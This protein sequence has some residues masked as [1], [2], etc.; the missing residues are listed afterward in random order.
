MFEA[1][2][3]IDILNGKCVRLKQGA[4]NA[5]TIYANDP[6]EIAHKWQ[7]AGAR[8]IHIVDLDGARTGMPKNIE[9]I[10][11]I[12]SQIKLPIQIGGGIRSFE[13]ITELIKFGVDRVIL[14][15]TAVKNPNLLSSICQEFP[16]NIVVSI[17][18]KDDKVT[19][20]GWTHTSRK[21]IFTLANEAINF[22]V[23]RFVYTDISRDGMLSGPN[24]EGI[25]R[26]IAKVTVPVIAS[27]G[28][29]S[30]LDI[31]NVSQ[32]GAEAVIVGKALYEGRIKP[33]ELF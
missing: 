16:D 12:V 24:I 20:D 18:A 10:K 22:G 31:E 28:I 6:L 2:P 15:T 26:F 4:Y 9:L 19:S 32:T 33:E 14:G 23:K 8:R 11:Q 27:G 1:I 30:K 17:D 21:D 29:G 5:E 3:A 25:K 13:L 7:N